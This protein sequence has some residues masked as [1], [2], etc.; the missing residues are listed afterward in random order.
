MSDIK[1]GGPA[2]RCE[3]HET[4]D[5]AWNHTF[6]PGMSL[7]DYF[8][9]QVLGGFM[10]AKPTRFNPDEDAGYCYRVADAMLAARAV[11]DEAPSGWGHTV[12]SLGAVLSTPFGSRATRRSVGSRPSM[13][14][15]VMASEMSDVENQVLNQ[16]VAAWNAFVHLPICTRTNKPSFG[17]R[18]MIFNVR[19]WF[20]RFAGR[21]PLAPPSRR[22]GD[23][24]CRIDRTATCAAQDAPVYIDDADTGWHLP[25]LADGIRFE[26]SCCCAQ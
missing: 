24:G 19:S 12:K 5:G 25:L 26:Q 10:A 18:S 14:E 6:D 22:D 8:A 21:R 2:F 11:A 4:Q 7:R 23:D 17:T 20:A 16:L 9:G 15:G 13:Q 3:Q 1:D